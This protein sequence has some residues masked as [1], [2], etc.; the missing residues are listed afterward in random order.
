MEPVPYAHDRGAALC[1]IAQQLYRAD[2]RG[3]D[4]SLFHTIW[5]SQ[6]KERENYI[7][8]EKGDAI[9]TSRYQRR[10]APVVQIVLGYRWC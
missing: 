5:H 8:I 6:K 10:L 7:I 9:T 4:V 3:C 1:R 2:R